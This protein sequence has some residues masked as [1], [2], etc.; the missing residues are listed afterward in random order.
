MYLRMQVRGCALQ[1]MGLYVSIKLTDD[2][3]AILKKLNFF[4]QEQNFL[5]YFK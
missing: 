3:K 5:R 4:E 2:R 1:T